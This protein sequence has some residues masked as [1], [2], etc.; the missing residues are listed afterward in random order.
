MLRP[1]S[2]CRGQGERFAVLDLEARIAWLPG[3]L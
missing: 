2:F 1:S 3:S